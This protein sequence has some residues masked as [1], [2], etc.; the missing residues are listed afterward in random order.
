M[1][2]L[3]ILFVFPFFALNAASLENY[4][5]IEGDVL[6]N[7][8]EERFPAIKFDSSLHE[9]LAYRMKDPEQAKIIHQAYQKHIAP[10]VKEEFISGFEQALIKVCYFFGSQ[11]ISP[12]RGLWLALR[13]E[14]CTWAEKMP[15]AINAFVLD[16]NRPA[17][18]PKDERA[19]G[20]FTIAILTTSASGGNES[21][22]HGVVGYLSRY[23]NVKTVVIDVE[24]LA[25]QTDLVMVASGQTTYDGMYASQFQQQGD[26]DILIERDIITRQLGKYIP[27]CLGSLLKKTVLEINPDL[28]I[29]TRSYTTDDLVLA[30]L[31]IPFR[32]LHCDHELSIFLLDSYGKSDGMKYWLPSFDP[33]VFKP[34]FAHL[35]KMN[36]YNENDNEKELIEKVTFLLGITEE[37]FKKQFAAVGYPTRPDFERITD[38]D[39]LENLRKKWGILPHEIPILVSMGKNG[40]GALEK[41]Y[42]QLIELPPHPWK[43]IFICGKNEELKHRLSLSPRP[44]FTICGFMCPKEMNELMNIASVILSKP[45]GAVT[46]EVFVTKTYLLMV[47]TYPWEIPNGNKIE[48]MGLGQY[49][50]MDL[51]LE[52]QIEEALIKSKNVRNS[53]VGEVSDW[54]SMFHNELHAEDPTVFALITS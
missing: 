34:L 51:S 33:E 50:D 7:A 29:S 42:E 26:E 28:I 18:L 4:Y 15:N 30:T 39:Q 14:G 19:E 5:R 10:L 52:A 44:D 35:E 31:D 47:G 9:E 27:S 49:V 6:I 53:S 2:T 40:V 16:A 54:K 1:K 41:L 21:V 3:L 24:E 48:K 46:S 43:F 32:M 22:T 20:P 38:A 12:E 45:G 25:R 8:Q 17:H 23:E 37:E 36:L 11:K 13:E